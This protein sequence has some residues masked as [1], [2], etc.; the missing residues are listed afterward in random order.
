MTS[1]VNGASDHEV[2]IQQPNPLLKA[3]YYIINAILDITK[4]IVV[5]PGDLVTWAPANASYKLRKDL[6]FYGL[7]ADFDNPFRSNFIS[8]RLHG[9]LLLCTSL[10]LD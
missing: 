5:F 2:H 10:L 7:A 3:L 4:D 1:R 8:S 9:I 6:E